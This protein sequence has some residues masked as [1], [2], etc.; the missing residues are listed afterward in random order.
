MHHAMPNRRDVPEVEMFSEPA[1]RLGQHLAQII[2]RPGLEIDLEDRR[3]FCNPKAQRSF[4]EIDHPACQSA[5]HG[6]I[7]LKQTDFNRRGTRIKGDQQIG[8][9]D[10]RPFM[11]RGSATSLASA[12][13]AI[14]VV[15][16]SDRLVNTIGTR[17]P[18]TRPAA[19]APA[20]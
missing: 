5:G 6:A 7:D 14:R 8:A 19:V 1:K 4:S 20:K 2:R 16:E 11:A 15:M 12:A 13:D 3:P 17:A 10:G 18:R 9:H